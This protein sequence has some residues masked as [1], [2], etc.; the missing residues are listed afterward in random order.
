MATAPSL[1]LVDKVLQLVV[2]EVEK[3]PQ[4][5][6]D[7]IALLQFVEDNLVKPLLLKLKL[8]AAKELK[9]EEVKLVFQAW[10][11]VQEVKTKCKLF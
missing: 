2:D 7:A 10:S 1:V 3:K 8:W 11:E 5:S 6:A 4:T 9:D